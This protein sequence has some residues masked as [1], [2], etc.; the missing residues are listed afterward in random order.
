[1]DIW[2]VSDIMQ[3]SECAFGLCYLFGDISIASKETAYKKLLP[4]CNIPVTG[5]VCRHVFM[6]LSG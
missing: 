1:M 4:H 6:D 3:K 2:S 5:L